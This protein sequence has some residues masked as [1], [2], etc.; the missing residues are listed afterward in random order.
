MIAP[1]QTATRVKGGW[2]I[3]DNRGRQLGV[4]P[5]KKDF[6]EMLDRHLHGPKRNPVE[7]YKHL[8]N[9]RKAKQR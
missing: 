1:N 2:M 5:A 8:I 6:L 9:Q 3:Y 4:A 7:S